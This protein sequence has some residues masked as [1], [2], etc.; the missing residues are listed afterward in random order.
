MAVLNVP[1]NNALDPDALNKCTSNETKYGTPGS[2]PVSE[3]T[4]RHD[5]YANG[6][7][8][9]CGTLNRST[10]QWYLT[11][12]G[13][14][15]NPD[16]TGNV[17][18]M[19]QG[20]VSVVPTLTQPLNNPAWNYIYATR[21]GNACDQTLAN[22]VGGG[23]W[24]Y[25]AGNL[26]LKQ[27]VGINASKLIVGGNLD[28]E[29]NAF[30]G[31]NTNMSTR[32]E[33]Y[34]GGTCRYQ[35]VSMSWVTCTGNQDSNNIFSK[36]SD[37]ATIGVNHTAPVVAPPAA[38]FA[39]WY[40]NAIPGPAQ[41]CTT[42]VGTPPTF[43]NNYPSRDN[44]VST[45]FD[46]TP[47]SSYACRVGPGRE[48][49]GLGR[50][51]GHTDDD[52]RRVRE[53]FPDERHLPDSRRRRGHDRHR[54]PGHH[55]VDSDAWGEQHDSGDAHLGRFGLLG[56][57][58]HERRDLLERDREDAHGQRHD[59]HR[60]QRQ[61]LADRELQRPG[62]ALSLGT[63]YFNGSRCGVPTGSSYIFSNWD[64][65]AEMLT[66]IANGTGGQVNT[67]D[68]ILLVNNQ[69]FQGGLFGTGNVEYG[70]NANSDGPIMGS[71][72]ILANNVLTNSFPNITPVPVGMP[73]NPNVY[74]QP[75]PPQF[76]SG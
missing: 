37:G 27:N 56:R 8:D 52:H 62:D 19:L 5:A 59:L 11:S 29:N 74:A 33:T 26:C 71:Q 12:I 30:V 4:W 9:W 13:I 18:R 65:N 63:M 23:A 32:T 51:D 28:L 22:N 66:I 35:K 55:D 47:A 53:R 2:S 49:D 41:S 73:G 58:D 68:S 70:Q 7:V 20:T 48:H 72:S 21:S 24:M 46:L 39:T 69:Y 76:F 38:D 16:R 10:A 25:I 36:L 42:S 57:L 75:N 34:V 45:P 15:K 14:M 50:D 54:R 43:D 64:P 3:S 61:G 17:T 6:T 44:S 67:G 60:R 40:E 31:A 1:T